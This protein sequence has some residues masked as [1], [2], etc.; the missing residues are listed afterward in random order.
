MIEVLSEAMHSVCW[1]YA[2]D[3]RGLEKLH[4]ADTGEEPA[5]SVECQ[6]CYAPHNLRLQKE[7]ENKRNSVFCAYD[8][9]YLCDLAKTL[10]KHA[11]HNHVFCSVLHVSF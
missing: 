10:I 3:F 2:A 4:K 6:L 7:L 9:H 11:G 5:E 1:L 8:M